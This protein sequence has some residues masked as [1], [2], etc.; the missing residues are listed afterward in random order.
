MKKQFL[1]VAATFA[2]VAFV[3]CRKETIGTE[4]TSQSNDMAIARNNSNPEALSPSAISNKGLAGWYYFNG[5]LKD[6]S[7]KLADA[8]S[9]APASV[10]YTSDRMGNPNK[11]IRFT[12]KYGLNILN[13][14]CNSKMTVSAWMKYYSD[15]SPF[16]HV[17]NGTPVT[18]SHGLKNYS[19]VVS[20]PMT[21]GVTAGPF[22]NSWHHVVA[23]Y[24]QKDLRLYVDGNFIGSSNNPT[25]PWSIIHNFYVATNPGNTNFWQGSVDDLVIYNRTLS[26]NEVVLLYNIYV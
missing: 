10:Y 12:G 24:D 5:D 9:T 18:L 25:T 16:F 26:H 22:D 8:V 21:T 2:I 23:T 20:T 19:G 15:T 14:P 1:I 3:S 17:V 7:G 4:E 11:A 13:V 6:A